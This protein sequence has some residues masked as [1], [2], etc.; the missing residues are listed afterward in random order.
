M[1][2]EGLGLERARVVSITGAGGKTSLMF[3]LAR[4]Y[5]AR[6]ER[7]LITTT[8]KIAREETEGW[9]CLECESADALLAQAHRVLPERGTK[10]QGG[11]VACAGRVRDGHRLAGFSPELIDALDATRRFDR[12]LVEAD[13]SARK[14]L[15]APAAHEPVI[16]LTTGALIAV[17][18]LSGLGRTLSPESVFR[19][20]IW[21]QLS[22]LALGSRVTPESLARCVL[23]P[24]GLTRGCPPGSDRLLFLN[25]ADS[26]Q[27]RGDAAVVVRHLARAGGGGLHRALT[28]QLRPAP[29][30]LNTTIFGSAP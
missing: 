6:G 11:I 1:L 30:V 7:V 16:P 22:G 23:H 17:A 19:A 9:P 12:I 29:D 10:R 5:I 3:A 15:K 24:D 26:D 4:E 21:S 14:P 20:E 13:G 2:I 28:G 27:R 8:T 18:G 25:Q